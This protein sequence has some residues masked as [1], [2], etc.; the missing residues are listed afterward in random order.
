MRRCARRPKSPQGCWRRQCLTV[1]ITLRHPLGGVGDDVMHEYVAL[2]VGVVSHQ[3]GGIALEDDVAPIARHLG[4]EA[5]AVGG[6]TAAGDGHAL[7]GE[8][9]RCC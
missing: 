6:D 5:G 9:C 7:D 4:V 2:P 3:V 1:A 8:C